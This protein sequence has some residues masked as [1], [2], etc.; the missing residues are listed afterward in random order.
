[1][2]REKARSQALLP[3][4]QQ[5]PDSTAELQNGQ[6]GRLFVRGFRDWEKIAF[7]C[8][9]NNRSLH[10]MPVFT[11]RVAPCSLLVHRECVPRGCVVPG[12]IMLG[13]TPF[14]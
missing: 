13:I 14:L 4:Q 12:S 11:C 9:N 1:M 7:I 6:P 8:V 5:N 2:K 10:S 3:S